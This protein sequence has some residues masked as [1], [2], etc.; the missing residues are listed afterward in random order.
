MLVDVSAALVEGE[1]MILREFVVPASLV[2]M[3]DT[4]FFTASQYENI[5]NGLPD[6]TFILTASGRYAAVLGGKDQRYYHDGTSLVGQSIA[7]VLAPAKAQWFIQQIQEALSSQKMQVVEYELSAH[8]VLGLPL[9][10]P[11]EAIWFEGRVSA[12]GELFWGERAVVWVASNIT[13]SKRMQQQLQEQALNDE[14]TGLCNRRGFM[15]ELAQAYTAHRLQ[16]RPAWLMSFDVDHFKAI[17]D[18][19]GHPAGDQALRDLAAAVRW[20]LAPEDVFCRLGGDEFAILCC[21]RHI[22]QVSGLARQLLEAGQQALQ[23]YATGSP[24]PALSVGIAHFMPT[25]SSLEDIMRRADQALYSAKLQGGHR[26]VMAD[27]GP[28]DHCIA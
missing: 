15:R 21:D 3:S 22:A 10:G 27:R 20:L 24:V 11:A 9:E 2:P 14:L 7:D 18:G 1:K 4:T 13:A 6:P 5:C 8:D 12:L 25:D 23:R 17:N 26:A 28:A 19:L 16:G